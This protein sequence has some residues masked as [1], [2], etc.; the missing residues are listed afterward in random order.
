MADTHPLTEEEARLLQIVARKKAAK[1]S[2]VS[3]NDVEQELWVWAL[4]NIK[5]IERYRDP[6]LEPNGRAKFAAAL[7][8]AAITAI[9]REEAAIKHVKPNEIT[10]HDPAYTPEVVEALLPLVWSPEDWPQA[11]ARQAPSGRVLDDGRTR[12]VEQIRDM[13]LDLTTAVCRL[14]ARDQTVLRHAYGDD[15]NGPA[16]AEK[17]GCSSASTARTLRE[18]ALKRLLKLL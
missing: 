9:T 2:R 5:W 7:H 17:L 15:L 12:Q 8:R 14:P 6:H 11:I 16:L 13:L 10:D 1:W 18:R 3:A 4:R